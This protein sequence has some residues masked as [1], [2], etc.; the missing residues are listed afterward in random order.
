MKY[1]RSHMP[2]LLSVRETALTHLSGLGALIDER[3]YLH[4]YPQEE[5]YKI[6]LWMLVRKVLIFNRLTHISMSELHPN[7]NYSDDRPLQ[8]LNID[9]RVYGVIQ[10]RLSLNLLENSSLDC[11]KALADLTRSIIRALPPSSSSVGDIA[12]IAELANIL[13][14]RDSL[15]ELLNLRMVCTTTHRCAFPVPL[16]RHVELPEGLIE[17]F[18]FGEC[19]GFIRMEHIE[20]ALAMHAVYN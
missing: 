20:A 8:G 12:M 1:S 17:S 3:F 7:D 19:T 18:L 16:Q 14:S 4:F 15:Q 13:L 6:K 5:S 11:S 9:R 2:F 10:K